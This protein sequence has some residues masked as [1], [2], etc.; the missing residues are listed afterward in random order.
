[1]LWVPMPPL[2]G[3]IRIQ[4][5]FHGCRCDY[6]EQHNYVPAGK[7]DLKRAKKFPDNWQQIV[8]NALNPENQ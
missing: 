1:M 3:F 7:T 6:R 4:R 5:F 8:A 2:V